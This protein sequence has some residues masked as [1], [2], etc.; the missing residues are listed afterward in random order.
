MNAKT[1]SRLVAGLLLM[2]G[3]ATLPNTAHAQLGG[4]KKKMAKAV[5]GAAG[6]EE[7]SPAATPS[8]AA[9]GQ[10]RRSPYNDNVLEMTEP[11]LDRLQA[12]VTAEAAERGEVAKILAALPDPTTRMEC[13]QRTAMTPE[14]QAL[15]EVYLADME[16]ANGDN[17][18]IMK[19]AE[20][21]EAAMRA[22]MNRECGES[23]TP[24]RE[25]EL[26][27]RPAAKGAEAGGF[28]DVQYSV[29]KER[30]APFCTAGAALEESEDGAS[31]PA[32]G[33]SDRLVY[34]AAEIEALRPRCA[35]LMQAL[36][37]S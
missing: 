16:K 25:T 12:A 33:T 8:T 21:M 18:A 36:A 31:V 15:L 4:L 26:Q 3:M 17:A 5:A 6:V 1:T 35:A 9:A 34:S 32:P 28:K 27:K 19:A 30:V 10:T 37:G 2:M 11:V 23:L 13:E 22:I 20:K 24:E 29:L 7:T 14:V